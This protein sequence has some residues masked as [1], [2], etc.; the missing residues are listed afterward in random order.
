MATIQPPPNSIWPNGLQTD[1]EG[2]VNFYP[3]G[4]NKV[5]ISTITWPEG[6]KVSS[7]FVYQDDKL[8]GFIDTKA[9]E[10]DNNDTTIDIN[11][12]YFN[13]DLDSI[14]ENTLTINAPANAAVN[15]KYGAVD[16]VLTKKIEKLIGKEKCEVKFDK[17]N[18]KVTI[19]VALD[20]T[21]VQFTEVENLLK[22]VL[23][24]DLIFELEWTDGFTP[25]DWLESPAPYDYYSAQTMA[26]FSLPCENSCEDNL[27]IYSEH[28]FL[29][30]PDGISEGYGRDYCAY[31]FGVNS[32]RGFFFAFDG[33]TNLNNYIV[34]EAYY[35]LSMPVGEWFS[36]HI[37]MFRDCIGV[38]IN[39]EEQLKLQPNWDIPPKDTRT[40]VPCFA[41]PQVRKTGDGYL[42]YANY[43]FAGKKRKF[44][45]HLNGKLMYDLLPA[46]DPTG[47]PCM[48]DL[49]SR[50]PFYNVGTGDF[51]YPGAEKAVQT[52]DLNW[53]TKSYAKLTEH[54]I[55]RLYHVPK[56]YTGT[57]DEYAAANGFKELIESPIPSEGY[58]MP[59]WRETETQLV[60]DWVETEPPIEEI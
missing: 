59:E 9:L 29:Q 25:V 35:S 8:V 58:W 36:Y 15:V 26:W 52:L 2:Y 41:R 21:E 34:G 19:A 53:D 5:D 17:N 6:T 42:N 27:E 43:A 39:D 7:P 3:L 24:R 45:V 13:V 55:R 20:T 4:T 46:L 14:M 37:K 51:I 1:S 49:V 47:A 31:T 54:G 10:I 28:I 18:N 48:F 11:Y 16:K 12:T 23:P 33:T 57:M 60:C 44:K 56:G 38:I 50:Q 32:S 40:F 30:V 22:R